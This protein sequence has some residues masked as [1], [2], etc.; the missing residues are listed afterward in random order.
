MNKTTEAG[1]SREPRSR[2]QLRRSLSRL[3][4]GRRAQLRRPGRADRGDAPHPGRGKKLD[5][6]EPVPAC[7]ELLHAAAGTGGAAA[8]DLYRLAVAPDRRRHH[9]RRSVHPARRRRHHGIEL[10]LRGLWQ[11]RL[12]RGGVLRTE[13]GG[14]RHRRPCRGPR[15]QTRVAQP[16]DDRARCHRLCRDLLFQRAL[17]DHH[18]RGGRHRLF[19]REERTA[20]IRRHR[21]WRWRQEGRR[22]RQPVRRG[23]AR[24]R[25]PERPPRAARKL[26]V[27]A[28]VGGSGGRTP[29]RARAG[30]RVQPDRAVLFQDGDGDVRRRLC[31][32]GLCRPAGGRALSLA[33]AAARCS[34]DSAWPKPRRAR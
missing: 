15:G 8:C 21:T 29:D 18:H 28:A 20:G 27:A 16:G 3:A 9:G 30:Q 22:R 24:A 7:A 32:A 19:R 34:T 6:R 23:I 33:A 13:G 4:A 12:R 11:C 26:G 5:L 2:H 31:S 14:A 1:A 17:P 10:H 25:A